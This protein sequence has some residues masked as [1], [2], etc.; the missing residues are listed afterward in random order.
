VLFARRQRYLSS[1]TF[2]GSKPELM[3]NVH[4]WL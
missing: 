1:V 2:D 3:I 4:V